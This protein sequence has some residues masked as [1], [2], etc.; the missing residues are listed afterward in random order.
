MLIKF[1]NI[2][3][4]TPHI[5]MVRMVLLSLVLLLLLPDADCQK[6]SGQLLSLVRSE[7]LSAN[8]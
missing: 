8:R 1:I 2:S 7:T 5:K 4:S 3:H 6:V